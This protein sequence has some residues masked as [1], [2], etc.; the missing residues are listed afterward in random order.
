MLKGMKAQLMTSAVL[1]MFV[2]MLAELFAFV[3]INTNYNNFSSS[4]S[5]STGAQNMASSLSTGARDFAAQSLQGSINILASYEE[6]PSLRKGNMV[7]NFS[8]YVS[9]LMVSGV[10]PNATALA[11]NSI[12]TGMEGLTLSAYNQ[13]VLRSFN[14]TAGRV[15]INETRPDIYQS[16]PYTISV[17]YLEKV[18]VNTSSGA[19]RYS[20]PVNAT[21]N[22]TGM[23]DLFYAQEGTYRP[24]SFANLGGLTKQLFGEYASTGSYYNFAY[25]TANVVAPSGGCPSFSASLSNSIILVTENAMTIT[26]SGCENGFAGLISTANTITSI[27]QV[28]Y[29]AYPPG[30]NLP[31]GIV[32]GESIL[33]YGPE[34]AAFNIEGLRNSVSDGYYFPAQA[35]AS[36]IGRAS[37]NAQGTSGQGIFTLSGFN[38]QAASFNGFSSY[39][40][41]NT[42][43]LPAGHASRSMFAWIYFTGNSLSGNYPIDSWGTAGAG[44][45]SALEVSSGNLIFTDQGTSLQSSFVVSPNTWHFVGYTYT[46]NSIYV[47]LYLDGQQQT[48]TLSSMPATSVSSSSIGAYGGYYFNGLISNAQIYNTSIPAS[49]VSMLYR[50]GLAGLPLGNRGLVGWWPLNGNA[51]DYSGQGNSGTAYGTGYILIP[52]GSPTVSVAQLEGA[53][54]YA[55][56]NLNAYFGGNNQLTA[57]AWVYLTAQTNGP[58]FGVTDSPPGGG[59]NM[60]FLSAAGLTV[61]G[62][63]WGV[64]GNTPL[65]YTAPAPG[66]YMVSI[67]YNPSGSGTEVFYVDGNEVGTG[68]GSYAGS[69][70]FDYWTT[71]VSGVVPTGVSSYFSGKIANVQAYT[72]ALSGAQIMSLYREG[73]GGAPVERA[74]IL[75][76]WP[77]NGNL[78]DYSGNGNGGTGSNV[79]FEQAVGGVP[80]ALLASQYSDLY[81]LPGIGSCNNAYECLNG[82]AHTLFLGNYPITNTSALQT[83]AF[84]G[85]NS[86]IQIPHSSSL[87]VTGSFSLSW[88]FSSSLPSTTSFDVEMVDARWPTDTTFDMQLIG[89]NAGG[90]STGL[91]GNVGNGAGTWLSTSLNYPFS[92]SQNTWYLFTITFTTSSYTMYLNGQQVGTGTYSG[93]PSLLDS[94]SYLGIGGGGGSFFNG[95]IANLQVY[96]TALSALQVSQIF[97]EGI[98][99]NPLSGQDLVGWWPLDGNSNDYSG[100]GNEGVASQNVAYPYSTYNFPGAASFWQAVGL[101]VPP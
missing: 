69:G 59:W 70:S 63:I 7:S 78:D 50:R 80:D 18:Y 86:V 94:N 1:L 84:N 32:P 89:N 33:L 49:N 47:A 36:Y 25:G 14:N 60:P 93:T 61:Y 6:N 76:W 97:H 26:G 67:T 100:N 65:S 2:L 64:N 53:G 52:S 21:L 48:M 71:Y 31:G 68:S 79:N 38:T 95:S 13:S 92:F 90:Q 73:I 44:E 54:D 34:L 27:P 46:S 51:N 42:N 58:I 12:S 24:I 98:A 4:L 29:L 101:G 19:F 8:F 22:L 87:A 91:H 10:M 74:G 30:V 11:S 55:Y 5:V 28:P 81:P 82:S 39:I 17:S 83:G 9:N 75:S 85:A 3:L 57:S 23:P 41:T 20:F 62:W 37:G 72:T 99:G 16:S 77:L 96:G 40:A 43:N 45:E 15:V 35:S 66:W 88:W 56:G